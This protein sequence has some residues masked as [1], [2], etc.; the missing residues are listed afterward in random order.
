LRLRSGEELVRVYRPP[1][2]FGKAF[3]SA[4]GSALWSVDPVAE[5]PASVRLSAFDG[6]PGVRPSYRQFTTYAATWEP[7]PDDGLPRYP[8]RPPDAP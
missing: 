3:C 5:M 8:E 1:D 7:I 6:D 2:G 4:C